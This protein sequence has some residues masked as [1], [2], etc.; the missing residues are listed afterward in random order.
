MT[1]LP[2]RP[3][4]LTPRA[5]TLVASADVI[6]DVI[7]ELRGIVQDDEG[8]AVRALYEQNEQISSDLDRIHPRYKGTADAIT[9]YAVALTDAHDR[10]E[11]AQSDLDD[12]LAAQR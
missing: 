11:R 3:D 5:A 6:L 9:E 1:V 8:K 12:A 4:E 10:A 2:G 7:G